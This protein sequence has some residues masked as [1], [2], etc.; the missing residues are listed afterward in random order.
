MSDLTKAN[1]YLTGKLI[2]RYRK[3]KGWSLAEEPKRGTSILQMIEERFGEAASPRLLKKETFKNFESQGTHHTEPTALELYQISQVLEVPLLALIM[4][5]EAPHTPPPFDQR[6][7]VFDI[8]MAEGAATQTFRQLDEIQ[9]V[10]NQAKEFARYCKKLAHRSCDEIKKELTASNFINK[11]FWPHL[12]SAIMI[13]S[14]DGLTANPKTYAYYDEARDTLAA[15]GV[16]VDFLH[17][18][19][20]KLEPWFIEENRRDRIINEEE[21]RF[22]RE[23][24]SLQHTIE[25]Y[26]SHNDINSKDIL[27]KLQYIKQESAVEHLWNMGVDEE[28]INSFIVDNDWDESLLLE[29]YR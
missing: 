20:L 19:N 17:C 4:D 18:D 25:M 24:E 12:Y 26:S 15:V 9:E 22:T 29:E 13:L 21:K 1:D 10:E 16:D 28:T 14:V 6:N 27:E 2:R 8:S 23:Q 5:Y 11:R 7:T 3:E